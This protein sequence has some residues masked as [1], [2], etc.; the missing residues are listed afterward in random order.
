[1][2]RDASA[3]ILRMATAQTPRLFGV[4]AFRSDVGGYFVTGCCSRS[5]GALGLGA[6]SSERFC[7]FGADLGSQALVMKANTQ[8]LH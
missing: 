1:M 6:N 4:H 2:T 8:G 7:Y 5:V 3:K